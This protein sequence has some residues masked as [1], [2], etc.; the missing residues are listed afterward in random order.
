MNEI[1]I[2]LSNTAP[3]LKVRRMYL[4]DL[5]RVCKIEPQAYGTHHWTRNNFV[6]ELEN[7]KA[8]Y[9]VAERDGK[10]VGY[11]GAWIIVDE[12]HVVTVATDPEVTRQGI[13]E[14]LLIEQLQIA[15]LNKVRALT[16]EVRL[17]NIP[18]QNLYRKYG[19]ESMGMRKNYY[20]DNQESALIMWT[21]DINLSKYQNLLE[22]RIQTFQK[23]FNE[24]T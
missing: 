8:I 14:A 19:F 7:E 13:A 10:V 21:E 18:A 22:E 24:P 4:D 12:M 17:S 15:L 20:E 16:L 5:D 11:A 9:L 6:Q 1:I 3:H 23:K 2:K